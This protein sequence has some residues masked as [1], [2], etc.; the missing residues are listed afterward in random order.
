MRCCD[1]FSCFQLSHPLTDLLT[2]LHYNPTTTMAGVV[3]A[4]M[5]AA[6]PRRS[7]HVRS[8]QEPSAASTVVAPPAVA[9][10]PTEAT[11]AASTSKPAAPAQQAPYSGRVGFTE[12]YSKAYT[13]SQLYGLDR[14]APIPLSEH[15]QRGRNRAIAEICEASSWK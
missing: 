2:L 13:M 12:A 15:Q 5:R 10:G 11:P 3:H 14:P 7:V 8:S 9:N 1:I 6:V 4:V